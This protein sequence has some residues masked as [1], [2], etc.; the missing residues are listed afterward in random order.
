M[1]V[2]CDSVSGMLLALGF[3]VWG[4][5]SWSHDMASTPQ[6][7]V[8]SRACWGASK[9]SDTESM[10]SCIFQDPYRSKLS[11]ESRQ[12]DELS[13]KGGDDLHPIACHGEGWLWMHLQ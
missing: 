11:V 4:N 1:S 13:L 7:A 9:R 12:P 6:G 2:R 5:S 8:G 10:A 3:R